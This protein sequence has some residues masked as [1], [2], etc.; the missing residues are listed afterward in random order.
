MDK[1]KF[2][3][4]G[5]KPVE[6]EIK[7]LNTSIFLKEMSCK[8]A[9]VMGNCEEYIDQAVCAV[10]FSVCDEVGNLLFTEDDIELITSSFNFIQIQEIA[11]ASFNLIKIKDKDLGK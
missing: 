10:L 9:V 1:A 8:G 6:V 3:S 4:F 5:I 11:T 7:S 2:L